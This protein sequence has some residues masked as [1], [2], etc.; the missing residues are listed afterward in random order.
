MAKRQLSAKQR[1]RIEDSSTNDQLLTG[2]VVARFG[3]QADVLP[4]NGTESIP[5]HIRANLNTVALNKAYVTDEAASGGVVSGDFV[6]FSLEKDHQRGVIE[7]VQ[8]RSSVLLRPDTRS[9]LRP[10]AA[11]LDAICIV[12]APLPEP[13]NNLVD[14]YFV[15]SEILAIEPVLV[16]NKM[17]MLDPH[18]KDD[19][20]RR[21]KVYSDLGYQTFQLSARSGEGL[22]EFADFLKSKTSIVVGQSGV[23]KSSLLYALIADFDDEI[24]ALSTAK[25]SKTKG[26]H[27]TTTSRLYSL[28]CG[29]SII[30][31]PGIRE[32]GLWH[33]QPSDVQQGFIEI[34]RIAADC[35]FRNCSHHSEPGC[36]VRDAV[37][38]NQIDP[39]RFASYRFIVESLSQTH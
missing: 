38:Q 21:F 8:S 16:C 27:T 15:A 37:D 29:G 17:D 9:R 7:S 26:R 20:Q 25:T 30:D 19:F 13:H 10:V 34:D 4:D 39:E 11:N 2:R 28:D 35:K 14:R 36:A 31:S 5:C 1:Q 24:G 18:A 33:L 12:I 32:F 22:E 23:G 6:L 3:K